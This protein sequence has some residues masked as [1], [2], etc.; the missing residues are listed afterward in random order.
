MDQLSVFGHKGREGGSRTS[1]PISSKNGRA[2]RTGSCA[3]SLRGS[4]ST[5]ESSSLGWTPSSIEVGEIILAEVAVLRAKY[6]GRTKPV[7]VSVT[8]FSKY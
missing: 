1:T 6:E 7:N 3:E 2:R 5:W 8:I 4:L